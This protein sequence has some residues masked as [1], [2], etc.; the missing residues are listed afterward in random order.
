MTSIEQQLSEAIASGEALS[1]TY[2]GGSQPGSK[3]MIVPRRLEDDKIFTWCLTSNAWRRFFIS[4]LTI[5]PD[6]APT[7]QEQS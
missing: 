3:R 1:V 4:K 7:T 6:D 5:V 2:A